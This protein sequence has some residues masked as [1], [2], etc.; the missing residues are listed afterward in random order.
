MDD[1]MNSKVE[2]D[3]NNCWQHSIGMTWWMDENNCG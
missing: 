3:E 1:I 2:V